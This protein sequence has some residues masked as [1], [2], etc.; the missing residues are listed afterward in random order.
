[1]DVII[2]AS[3]VMSILLGEEESSVVRN[4]SSGLTLISSTCL[5]FE[6]GNSLTSA[7][8][9]HRLNA[10]IIDEV[11]REFLK[12][13]IRLIEPNIEKALKIAAEEN[14]YAY[15]AYY[16]ECALSRGIPLFSLDNGLIEI[17]KKRGVK[18]L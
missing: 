13:P 12:M 7:V 14:H 4:K 16:I 2:D 3:C 15:D 10:E 17:A 18:C 1:M 9:R 5:P 6:V 8:K 11:F